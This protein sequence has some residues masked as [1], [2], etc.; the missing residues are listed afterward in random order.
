MLNE[1]LVELLTN[2]GLDQFIPCVLHGDTRII[3]NFFSKLAKLLKDSG[4]LEWETILNDSMK[5]AGFPSAKFFVNKQEQVDFSRR[6]HIEYMEMI[7]PSNLSKFFN[8]LG[9]YK[10][11]VPLVN[12]TQVKR[13]I[14]ELEDVFVSRFKDT[15][16]AKVNLETRLN[17]LRKVKEI[18]DFVGDNFIKFSIFPPNIFWQDLLYLIPKIRSCQLKIFLINPF[19][20]LGK[21]M[22][23]IG[24]IIHDSLLKVRYGLLYIPINF[25]DLKKST[26]ITVNKSFYEKIKNNIE[27]SQDLK[28]NDIFN[29]M[30]FGKKN[31][32]GTSLKYEYHKKLRDS[33]LY[34]NEE[35]EFVYHNTCMAFLFTSIVG[36][37]QS[38][39][40]HML[41]EH[42]VA[43]IYEYGALGLI[44]FNF[45]FFVNDSLN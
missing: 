43:F 23:L 6:N 44:S 34:R 32:K 3:I 31:A 2:C 9:N 21:V 18:E 7:N 39:Y 11:N 26:K 17:F 24:S 12:L 41:L 13:K 30:H 16:K 38:D 35:V 10:I 20:K 36:E 22:I 15:Y 33:V 27:E 29:I 37:I 4:V 19:K 5:K 14:E 25:E 28:I 45:F 8:E 1:K 42:Y 40:F